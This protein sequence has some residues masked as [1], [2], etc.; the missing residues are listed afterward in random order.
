MWQA[1]LFRK[2][3]LQRAPEEL[4]I[5]PHLAGGDCVRVI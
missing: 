1:E 4:L 3:S 2:K 5:A